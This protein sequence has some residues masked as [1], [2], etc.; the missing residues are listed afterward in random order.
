MDLGVRSSYRALSPGTPVFSSDDERIGT[1]AHV[2]ADEREDTFDGIVIGEHLFGHDHRFADADEVAD[3]FE[4]GVVLKLD[5]AA[6]AS[7][8][9]P[10]A[11]PAVMRDDPAESKADIRRELLSRVWDRIVGRY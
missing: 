10:S 7:L 11:N 6:C 9:V 4:R 2:L 3:V 8:P 5:R 1:V